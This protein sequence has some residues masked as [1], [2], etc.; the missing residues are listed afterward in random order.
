LRVPD[1]YWQSRGQPCRFPPIATEGVYVEVALTEAH[2]LE[3]FVDGP[4]GHA[5]TLTSAPIA[6]SPPALSIAVTWDRTAVSLYLDG[7]RVAVAAA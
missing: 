2:C 7:K 3:V 4:L 1:G 6:N 5:W